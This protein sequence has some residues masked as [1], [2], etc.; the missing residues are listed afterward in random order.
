MFVIGNIKFVKWDFFHGFRKYK[1]S[2]NIFV[3]SNVNVDR[4][5]Y[6]IMYYLLDFLF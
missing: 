3:V 4:C 1:A 5:I 6:I 2:Y